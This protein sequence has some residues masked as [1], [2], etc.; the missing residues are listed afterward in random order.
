M[1]LID[2]IEVTKQYDS[3]VILKQINLYIKPG[4]KIA[5]AGQNGCGKSTLLNI[6]KGSLEI[7]DGKRVQTSNIKI[8]LLAQ[9]LD[10]DPNL[11][12]KETIELELQDIHEKQK[13]Y[14]ELNIRIANDYEEKDLSRLEELSN[15]FDMHNAWD[16]KDKV[17]RVLTEFNLEQ[18]ALKPVGLLSGG[19]QKRVA[20]ASLLLKEPEVILLDEPTNHLDVYM[21]KFLE[22]MLVKSKSTI[23]FISHDR[24]FIDTLATRLIEVERGGIRSFKGGYKDYLKAKRELLESMQK[25]QHTLLKL[26]KKEEEWLSRGVKARLKRNEGRKKRVLQLRQ[27]A[28]ENKFI[29]NK[30]SIELKREK[31]SAINLKAQNKHKMLFEIK[32]ISKSLGG[33]LLIKDFDYRILIQDTIAIVG[34]NGIGKSTLL[35]LLLKKL[36]LDKGKIKQGEFKVGYFDQH[37]DLLDMDK[38]LIETFCPNG[39]DRVNVRGNNIH[40]YGYLKNFL[41]PKEH[42][43]KKIKLL[44]GGEQNRVALALLFTKNYDCLI[45]DEPTNDLDIQTINILEEYLMNFKGSIIFVSHDRYFVDKIAK[46]LLI[47]YDNGHI[48]ESFKTYTEVLEIEDELEAIAKISQVKNDMPIKIKTKNTNQKQLS[49]KDKI[50]Y[51]E[52]VILIEKL[53]LHL[54]NLQ[55]KLSDPTIYQEIGLDKLHT[56]FT[57]TQEKLDVSIERFLELEEQV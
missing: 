11:T 34:K 53:E 7:D 33:K 22:K 25:S 51:E 46:K 5:I 2:L 1:A 24:Y 42:L 26:L 12:T 18:Y 27:D 36:P 20:L 17:K 57:N 49:Y 16:I 35:K 54:K 55:I 56:D 52:L 14:D 21:V 30:I 19:E 48:Q 10:L 23:V 8:E 43:T 4:E 38:D 50:E 32:N 39:G 47:M 6:I 29:T 9:K 45:L 37:L 15:Y 41:F 31:S 3:Q 40:V 28:K 44:S 13:E